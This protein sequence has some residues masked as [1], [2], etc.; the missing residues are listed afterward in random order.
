MNSNSGRGNGGP[1]AD[2]MSATVAERFRPAYP[3]VS[4]SRADRAADFKDLMAKVAR[5]YL[6]TCADLTPKQKQHLR[7]VE[8]G[9]YEFKVFSHLLEIAP[10]SRS[11][12]ALTDHLR[13]ALLT[14]LPARSRGVKDTSLL[15]T[16][17]QG[18]QNLWQ[19]RFDVETT[20]AIRDAALDAT[21]P[22]RDRLN[23]YVDS[24]LTWNPTARRYL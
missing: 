17:A 1:V 2:G 11:P 12:F 16:E 13:G 4:D 3:D 8:K 22:Y 21:L 18:P 14:R 24:L 5:H 15:E 9:R 19:H 10:L 23:D 7:D 20:P 6:D